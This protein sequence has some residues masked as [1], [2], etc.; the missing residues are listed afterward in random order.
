MASI[1][2]T[3]FSTFTSGIRSSNLKNIY[4]LMIEYN[5][6]NCSPYKI[7]NRTIATIKNLLCSPVYSSQKSSDFRIIES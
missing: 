6:V 7:L 2:R 5:F 1:L 4:F 3:I